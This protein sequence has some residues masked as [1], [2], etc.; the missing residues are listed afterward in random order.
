MLDCRRE[1]V[2]RLN[3]TLFLGEG[4]GLVFSDADDLFSFNYHHCRVRRGTNL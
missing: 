2:G 3:L 4:V 1:R